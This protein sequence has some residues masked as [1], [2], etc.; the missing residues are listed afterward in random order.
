MSIRLK[1]I[2]QLQS[3]QVLLIVLKLGD[4]GFPVKKQVNLT[5]KIPFLFTLAMAIKVWVNEKGDKF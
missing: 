1:F 3:H 2:T 4:R 5:W